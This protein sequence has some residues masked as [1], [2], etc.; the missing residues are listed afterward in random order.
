MLLDSGR[1]A[2]TAS[3]EEAL[4]DGNHFPVWN[5]FKQHYLPKNDYFCILSVEV[6]VGFLPCKL[7][8]NLHN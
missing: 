1:R 2:A 6:S 7:D 3:R 5:S 4:T 8:I